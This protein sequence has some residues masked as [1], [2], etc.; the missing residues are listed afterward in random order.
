MM[1]MRRHVTSALFDAAMTYAGERHWPVAPGI[2]L[3][4][5]DR[6]LLVCSCGRADCPTPGAHP[7]NPWWRAQATTDPGT[8]RW[9]WTARPHAPI[10]VPTGHSFDVLDVSE[11]AGYGAVKRLESLG[12]RLG[13]VLSTGDGR[14][15]FFVVPGAGPD[16][17]NIMRG[18]DWTGS[19]LDIEC[20]GEG[21]FVFLPPSRLGMGRHTRW[22]REPSGDSR[23]LPDAR[24]LLTSIAYACYRLAASA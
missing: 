12:L 4:R 20:R 11:A 13:P 22:I 10:L 16:V 17:E 3:V 14:I 24:A 23:R 5:D 7:G 18:T 9:W 21:D 8:I 6:M 15:Q 19:Q 2:T 1:R